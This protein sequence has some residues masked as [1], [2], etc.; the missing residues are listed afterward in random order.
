DFISWLRRLCRSIKVLFPIFPHGTEAVA[1]RKSTF[2]CIFPRK[3]IGIKVLLFQS[4]SVTGQKIMPIGVLQRG[5]KSG[6]RNVGHIRRFAWQMGQA[7]AC[8]SG[9]A[10]AFFTVAATTTTHQIFPGGFTAA[11]AWKNVIE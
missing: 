4:F 6:E 11:A 10:I 3:K 8:F 7:H 9:G 2:L 5:H 1:T